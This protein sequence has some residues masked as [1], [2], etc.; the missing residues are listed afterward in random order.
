MNPSNDVP[1][2]VKTFENYQNRFRDQSSLFRL[3]DERKNCVCTLTLSL[4]VILVGKYSCFEDYLV[5]KHFKNVQKAN[6]M[7]PSSILRIILDH[8]FKN[9]INTIVH[10]SN[11]DG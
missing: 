6:R 3:I 5:L 2:I 8:N 4:Y 10:H 7:I 9:G 11:A 1:E